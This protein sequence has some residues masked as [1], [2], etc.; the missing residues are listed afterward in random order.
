MF[1]FVENPLPQMS[2]SNGFGCVRVHVC[3]LSSSLA[4]KISINFFSFTV[5]TLIK[6]P[7]Y[8]HYFDKLSL[9]GERFT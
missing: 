2:H 4:E 7:F 9:I 3:V 8:F 1:D 5:N 6:R